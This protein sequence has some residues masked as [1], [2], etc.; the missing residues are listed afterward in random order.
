MILL[1]L[2][3]ELCPSATQTNGFEKMT[4]KNTIQ[5]KTSWLSK[6]PEGSQLICVSCKEARPVAEFWDSKQRREMRTCRVCLSG[7]R[8]ARRVKQGLPVWTPVR[9]YRA[10]IRSADW[11]AKREEFWE[12]GIMRYCY[13][14]NTPWV[15]FRGMELHHR[16]YERLGHEELTDLVPVCPEHHAL[17]T[18]AWHQEKRVSKKTRRSLWEVT[19][20]VRLRFM[21]SLDTP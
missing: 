14:C 17:I 3:V 4:K 15:N 19:D 1:E 8:N 18:K 6:F 7:R 16:T 12:S 2:G 20:L 21:E 11:Y 5:K 13:V 10:Y 9:D